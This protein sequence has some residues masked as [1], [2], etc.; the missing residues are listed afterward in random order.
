MIR[1]GGDQ[2]VRDAFTIVELLVVIGIIAILAALLMP[3]LTQAKNKAKQIQCTA[4]LRQLYLGFAV[5]ANYNDGRAMPCGSF[6]AGEG[7]LWMETMMTKQLGIPW[8]T[9]G[10][11]SSPSRIFRCPVLGETPGY[12]GLR[13]G[14]VS[15][16]VDYGMSRNWGWSATPRKWFGENYPW[17]GQ[18][19]LLLIE[20]GKN[21]MYTSDFGWVEVRHSGGFNVLWVD[22]SVTFENASDW[23]A[24][25]FAN[26]TYLG[27]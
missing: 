12:T 17:L 13:T 20:S 8:T 23:N 7:P 22:G 18:K 27:G 14:H 26:A 19:P 11:W 4:N 21:W 24:T 25:K 16:Y 1:S 6:S 9:A 3:A 10:R 15:D 5:Y 2:V